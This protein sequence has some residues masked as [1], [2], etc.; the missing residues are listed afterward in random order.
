MG[1]E[2]IAVTNLV[3]TVVTNVDAAR[4]RTNLLKLCEAFLDKHTADDGAA[5]ADGLPNYMKEVVRSVV[6]LYRGFV[7]LLDPTHGRCGAAAADVMFVA[8]STAP[9]SGKD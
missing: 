7:T 1:L 2:E 5:I 8:P 6:S 3:A 4:S 9:P